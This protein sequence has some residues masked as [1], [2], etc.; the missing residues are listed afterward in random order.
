[1]DKHKLEQESAYINSL[2]ERWNKSFFATW[3]AMLMWVGC[4]IAGAIGYLASEN[5][6]PILTSTF[7]LICFG[8]W[9]FMR[10]ANTREFHQLLA[11][12]ETFE[13]LT[14]ARFYNDI[15]FGLQARIGP[16]DTENEA[17]IDIRKIETP[18]DL[19][20]WPS[21]FAPEREKTPY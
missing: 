14:G 6:S 10:I 9:V 17:L 16:V 13:N 1:M 8:I 4:G 12:C 15:R 2:H 11:S 3:L 19:Y 18:S 5:E 20:H 21:G 7:V